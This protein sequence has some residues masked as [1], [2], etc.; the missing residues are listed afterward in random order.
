[1][2]G[3]A[4]SLLGAKQI[5]KCHMKEQLGWVESK[6][7][8]IDD[9]DVCDDFGGVLKMKCCVVGVVYKS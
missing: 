5:R 1:M 6:R 3:V 8:G 7:K 4:L 2:Q 9:F